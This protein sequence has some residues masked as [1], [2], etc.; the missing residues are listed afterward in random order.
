MTWAHATYAAWALI[1]LGAGV[2]WLASRRAWPVGKTRVA[3]PSALLR[4]LL[5]GRTWLRVV[6]VLGWIWVGVHAFAR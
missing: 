2:L 3:R 1:A 4:D 6:V 5:D